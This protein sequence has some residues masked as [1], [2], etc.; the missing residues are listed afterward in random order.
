MV[1]G[2]AY[3]IYGFGLDH[4]VGLDYEDFSSMPYGVTHPNIVYGFGLDHEEFLSI[5]FTLVYSALPRD[6]VRVPPPGYLISSSMDYTS[7]PPA[8]YV[9]YNEYI[10]SR[11][12]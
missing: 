9:P 4:G 8:G 7:H 12:L 6:L 1:H 5:L 2:V 3:L 10:W 11:C